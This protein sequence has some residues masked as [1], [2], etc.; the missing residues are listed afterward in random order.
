MGLDFNHSDAHWGYSGFNNFRR[1]LAREINLDLD[2]MEGFGGDFSW[3]LVKDDIKDFLN[4]SDCD[5][6]LTSEQCKIIYP[7]I[8]ELVKNWPNEDYDKQEAII[9]AE[10]MK[11]CHENNLILEF[12]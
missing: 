12:I 8:L 3:D 9:L 11:Y 1:K 7:R 6:Y 10:D 5:G 4:H 2:A